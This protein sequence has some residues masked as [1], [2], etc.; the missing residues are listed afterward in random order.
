MRIVTRVI[1]VL[2]VDGRHLASAGIN[3]LKGADDWANPLGRDRC[4]SCRGRVVLLTG[5]NRRAPRG[6][7]A[8]RMC[9]LERPRTCDRYVS[10]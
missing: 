8:A 9:N 10:P 4:G 3:V 6:R 2:M 1:G 7:D 5:V